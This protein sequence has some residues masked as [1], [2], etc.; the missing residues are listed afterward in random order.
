MTDDSSESIAPPTELVQPRR[1]G[2]RFSLRALMLLVLVVGAVLGWRANRAHHQKR[3]V[4]AIK[5]LNGTVQYDFEYAFDRPINPG[6]P[7]PT[8]PDG[9]AWLRK[10]IGD[11]YFQEV[12]LV[13]F[14][15]PLTGPL[16]PEL[17]QLDQVE[18]LI[19]EVKAP[20]SDHLAL[21][22]RLISL[23]AVAPSGPG[24]T[25]ATVEVV[26]KLPQLKKLQLSRTAVTDAGL[27]HIAKY[28]HLTE[29]GLGNNPTITE[30]GLAN[31]LASQPGLDTLVLN[32]MAVTDSVLASLK[33]TTGLR[34]LQIQHSTLT[35]A[36]LDS[37]KDL[38]DLE[39][40]MINAPESSM[41]DKGLAHLQRLVKLR[42]L[43]FTASQVGDD[44]LA[45][46]EGLQNL[47]R[48]DMLTG[49]ADAGLSHITAL[50]NLKQVNLI[51]F[52]K[53]SDAG[54]LSLGKLTNLRK[55]G[56]IGCDVSDP[57]LVH[58]RGLK[59]LRDLD[60]RNTPVTDEAI[61]DF[62]T[63]LPSVRIQSGA[64]KARPKPR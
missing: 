20:V 58:L 32:S 51:N 43:Y 57:E 47:E 16:P 60:L 17:E 31:L 26:A 10:L 23:K 27:A 35:D 56:L 40:L 59:A 2:L 45:A 3:A 11:E 53:L 39:Y 1:R 24:I 55:L 30:V 34:R 18:Y 14:R 5:A 61:A 42:E 54:L 52:S 49:L 7:R 28:S 22:G 8:A 44:G 48:L 9:P 29:I 21:L 13:N 46:L 12:T 4:E 62:R 6:S 15:E 50:S 25:D 33:N 38:T 63:A 41:T 64:A 37:I 36:G 19:Y